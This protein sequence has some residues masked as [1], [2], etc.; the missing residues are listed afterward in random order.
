MLAQDV[1]LALR[2]LHQNPLFSL[3]VI[4]TLALGIGGT[5][6]MY[7]VVDG[8]LLKPLPFHDP[9]S[10]VRVTADYTGL[11]MR[12]VGM[13]LPELDDYSRRTDTFESIAGIWPITGNL[14]GGERPERVEVLLASPNYFDL[15]GARAAQGRTFSPRDWDPGIATVAVI[16]DGLWRRAFGANAAI[17][18]RTIHLDNDAYTIIGV[19][20]SSFRHP[21]VTLVTDVDLWA[22]AGWKSAPFPDP[23]YSVRFIPSAIG[24]LKRSVSVDEARARVETL[25]RAQVQQHPNQYPSRVAWQPRV[26][27]LADDLVSGIRPMLWV[28]MGA[29]AFVLIIAITSISNLLLARAAAREREI[30]VQ[31][32]LGADRRRVLTALMVEGLVLAAVGGTAGLLISLWGVDALLRLVPD[33]L[34]RVAEIGVDQRVFL[35]TVVISLVAGVLMSAAPALQSMRTDVIGN[36]KEGGRSVQGGRRARTVRSALV[37]AQIAIA[38][39]LLTGAGLFVRS[40]RNAQR[41]ETGVELSNVLTARTWLPQPNDP[42]SGPYFEHSARVALIRRVIDSVKSSPGIEAVGLGMSMPL[43]S[44]SNTTAFA[45]EGWTP[46]RRELATTTL[47]SVTPG[48]FRALRVQLARGRLLADSDDDRAPRAIVVNEQFAKTYFPGENVIDKRVRFVSGRGQPPPNAPWLTIVGL[49][50][51]I[52]EDGVDAPVRP[53]IYQSLWQNSNLNLGIVAR[54]D[55][56]IPEG[57]IIRRALQSADANLPLYAVRTG[58]ELLAADLAQRRFAATLV[59][60]FA[61]AALLLAA[62]GLHGVIAFGVRQRLHEFGLRV[63]LGATAGR[64][65]T[66]VLAQ[67]AR[68]AAAG[69]AIGVLAT[70]ALSRFVSSLLFNV[71]ARDPLTLGAV[72]AVLTIVVGAATAAA[73]YRATR[74]E[75]TVALRGE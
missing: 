37:I 59:N 3:T 7:T 29:I 54:G 45:A 12:D 14:T 25:G 73:A 21:S 23:G 51:D 71:N 15:L 48:Y 74:V 65:L 43:V 27:P 75:G 10:L 4:F 34:P 20:P 32:A 17:V 5:T 26:F 6:A 57:D 49:I 22:P 19:M 66:L 50:R 64:I 13:S 62:L 40:L 69:V 18:G 60:V 72:V 30:A 46:D 68:L 55:G 33:R 41:V 56:F 42:K 67:G 9:G 58:E 70:L 47:T 63:A 39:V 38:I 36:L 1:R 2:R 61:S 28:L 24:R 35:F 16:S 53:Q 31:R 11:N 44:D 8:V 52:K